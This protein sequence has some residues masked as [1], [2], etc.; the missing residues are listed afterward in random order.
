MTGMAAIKNRP[1][2]GA[3]VPQ[4]RKSAS[5]SAGPSS[6]CSVR[7]FGKRGP[8]AYGSYVDELLAILPASGVVGDRKFVHSNHLYSVAALTDNGGNAVERYRYD[9]HGQRTVLAADST[10]VRTGSLY[11]NQAGFAGRYLDKETGL[12]YF[13]ARCYSGSLGRFV[14]RDPWKRSDATVSALDGYVDGPSLYAAYFVPGYTDPTGT[15]LENCRGTY[16]RPIPGSSNPGM[17]IY[18]TCTCVPPAGPNCT[19]RFPFGPYPV[20]SAND[21]YFD[22][23]GADVVFNEMQDEADRKAEQLEGEPCDCNKPKPKEKC[24]VPETSPVPDPEPS[25]GP[26]P[27]TPRVSDPI[28]PPII[29]PGS[30]PRPSPGGNGGGTYRPDP[31]GG[32]GGGM[33]GGGGG[34]GRGRGGGG[35][36]RAW[37]DVARP[38]PF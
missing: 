1:H 6:F 22:V 9:A 38:F 15:N 21:D 7:D 28:I 18:V 3:G 2:S 32:T 13:R 17:M 12:W 31:G 29:P 30:A 37:W 14:S 27:D 23:M 8:V 26:T 19:K 20:P 4:M 11:G 34:G 5:R 33:R 10:T 36:S 35:G 24:D 25:P 16:T